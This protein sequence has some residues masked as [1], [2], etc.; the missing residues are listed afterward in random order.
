MHSLWSDED[1]EVI[2]RVFKYVRGTN[3]AVIHQSSE[4]KKKLENRPIYINR[5]KLVYE[6]KRN[7]H[8]VDR[9]TAEF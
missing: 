8:V 9:I 7:K 6:D 4:R 1:C 3:K 5:E 2:L